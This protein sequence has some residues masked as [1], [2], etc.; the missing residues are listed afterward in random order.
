MSLQGKL[1]LAKIVN[2]VV[3][4]L[5]YVGNA[6]NLM[7]KIA[8]DTLEHV[9][10]NTGQ[11][12]TDFF[13]T[14]TTS[15]EFEG[16]L[17]EVDDENLAYITNGTSVTIASEVVVNRSL[18]TVVNGQMIDLNAYNLTAVSVVDS[19]VTPVTVA[20]DK[21]VLDAAFGT[22]EAVDVTG[23]TMPLKISFTSGVVAATT[24]ASNFDEESMLFFKGVNTAN[25]EKL[26]V[27]LWRTKKNP[28]A[29]FPLIHEELG[30]WKISG[31][32]M[33]DVTKGADAELG[34]YGHIVRIP[35]EA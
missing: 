17:D 5:R 13:M 19:S 25:D 8:G 31:K 32:A 21:Y 35:A 6:P 34:Y 29:E 11:R 4:S 30:T 26:A 1:H 27:K 10:S 15:V 18:G 33:S 14:K 20:A 24:L 22:I 9:E 12:T 16:E 28:E 23:L 7:L 3:S 2:G